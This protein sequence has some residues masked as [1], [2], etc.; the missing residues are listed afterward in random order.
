VNT[1]RIIQGLTG[2][3]G[4]L[5]AILVC[6]IGGVNFSAQEESKQEPSQQNVLMG[7]SPTNMNYPLSEV[8][9][10]RTQIQQLQNQLTFCNSD[11]S[12]LRLDA[13]MNQN[14]QQRR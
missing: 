5:L 13:L 4:A 3:L 6:A 1:S 11:V 14:S 8:N 2:I 7:Q 10:L 12:R 9:Q